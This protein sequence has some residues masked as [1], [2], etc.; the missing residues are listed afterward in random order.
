M[1]TQAR[2]FVFTT[3]ILAAAW[4]QSPSAES[5]KR[6]T[7]FLKKRDYRHAI[8]AYTESIGLDPHSAI[9]FHGRGYAYYASHDVDRAIRDFTEAIRLEPRYGDAFRERARA[10]EEKFDYNRAIQDY[11]EA[12]RIKPAEYV[13]LYD[14]AYDYQRIGGYALAVADLDELVRRFPRSADAY[15]DRGVAHLLW[16]H[17]A[18]AQRDISRAV[19][20]NPS[21]YYDVIWLYLARAK[22]GPGAEK[23]LAKN[24]TALNLS[25]WPGP[26]IELFLG[27]STTDAVLQ[28]ASD[29]DPEK[30]SRQQCQANFY[31]AEYQAFH[32]QREA[33]RKNFRLASETCNRNYFLY[34]ESA[35]EE[36]KS[37]R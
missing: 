2:A 31:I 32:G 23:E 13:L 7:D 24:A 29:K 12:I 26:V 10:Y 3:C 25:K 16:G 9:A 8:E 22:A 11:A 18:E 37:L 33:A 6:G 17:L 30:N 14:R 15:R 5:F 34:V 21:G 20:L 28:A 19:E 35:Q 27:K 36:L 4:A 1:K